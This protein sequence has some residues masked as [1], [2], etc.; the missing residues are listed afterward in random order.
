MIVSLPVKRLK[1]P[2]CIMFNKV[3]VLRLR[4]QP[5]RRTYREEVHDDTVSESG[6]EEVSFETIGV[7]PGNDS[8]VS[9][10]ITLLLCRREL[11]ESVLPCVV[12]TSVM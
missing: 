9:L 2:N 5:V 10:P 4:L 8:G 1:T 6:R 12:K 7:V 11:T 3:S